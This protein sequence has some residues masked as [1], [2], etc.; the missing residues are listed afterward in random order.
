[1]ED[2]TRSLSAGFQ[3]HVAKP[4]EPVVLLRAVARWGA[5]TRL[6][7]ESA[8][9]RNGSEEVERGE[10]FGAGGVRVL[11]VEDDPDAREGLRR[12]LEDWGYG[13]AVARD[14]REALEVARAQPAAVALV[15]IGLPEIDGYAVA[16]RLRE[17]LG[18]AAPFL[19]ALTGHAAAEDRS[20]ALSSGF[21]AYLAKPIDF[22]RLASLIAS[23]T[24]A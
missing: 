13:V 22:S 5:R 21:D 14:G 19:V 12:L 6:Q 10:P 24:T 20:M 9:P 1:V 23:R 15:D 2:R 4:F 3:E 17:E 18:E 8:T 16:R 7:A 11:V